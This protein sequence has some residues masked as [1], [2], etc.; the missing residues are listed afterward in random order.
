MSTDRAERTQLT[1]TPLRPPEKLRPTTV[2]LPRPLTS[3][4]GR[5]P[6]L[7]AVSSLLRSP[8]VRLVTLTGPGG[9]GK[10]RLAIQAAGTV[11]DAFAAVHFVSLAAV[12]DLDLVLPEIAQSLGVREGGEQSLMRRLAQ[13]FGEDPILLLLDNFEQVCDAATDVIE[14]LLLC[15]PLKVL[16]TSREVLH[17]AGEHDFPVPP[18]DIPPNA[19]SLTLDELMQRSAVALFVERARASNSGFALSHE[20]IDEVC[21]V[22][23]R[24][25]GL[26]LAIELVAAQSRLLSPAAMLTRLT[27]RLSLLVGGPRDQPRR[28]RTMRDAISWSYDL[29][30]QDEQRLFRQLSVFD[31]GFTVEAAVSVCDRPNEDEPTFLTRLAGLIDKS[32]LLQEPQLDG[33]PRLRMLETIREYGL[34]RLHDSGHETATCH[35]HA[36]YYLRFAAEAEPKLI[37][38]GSADWVERLATE[39]ANIRA[40]V[41]WSLQHGR[42]EPVLRLAGTLLSLGYARGHPGEGLSWLESALADPGDSSPIA[43]I[44]ALF[45]ASALA[46]VQGDFTR[47]TTLSDHAIAMARAYHYQFGEARAEL[48]LGITAEWQRDLEQAALRYRKSHELMRRVNETDRLAHW[49]ILPLANLADVA[50]IRGDNAEA[51]KIGEE[52]VQRWREAGY[53]WGIAQALGTV[54]AAA[55]ERGKFAQAANLY[56]ET[57]SHWL[58]CDDGRGIA[59]TIAGIAGAARMCGRLDQATRLLGA[60][61]SLGDAL[62]VRFL[63]HHL[64]AE[65]VRDEVRDRLPSSVF[66]AA[67]N[68]GAT[69]SLDMAIDEARSELRHVREASR[70]PHRLTPRELEVLKHIV[71]GQPDREI[72]DLLCISPRTVQSHVANVFA[73]LNANTRAEAVAIAVRNGLV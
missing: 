45:C 23:A 56:E 6:E 65:R 25:D 39:Q 62:G 30:E 12:R 63:A 10:T 46:Q 29:L 73:K 52:A 41:C 19:G 36:D 42:A 7:E 40:A 69:L 3:F 35:A 57:L 55:A 9:A 43:Q 22:C 16:V 66:E 34:E 8:N 37:S 61:W 26:P 38:A 20:N 48:G 14:L 44:D 2:S 21:A 4:I 58:A 60:A 11:Q 71:N 51:M 31:G 54:A 53:V 28:L 70:P 72:A 5:E 33:E 27:N 64:Y 17:V 49:T 1:P 32:L 68:A 47:S 24:L 50:L 67:W 15:P 18:L 13:Y 59:G